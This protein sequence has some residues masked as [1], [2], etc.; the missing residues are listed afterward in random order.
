MSKPSVGPAHSAADASTH[1]AAHEPTIEPAIEATHRAADA[2]AD[3]AAVEPT[4]EAAHVAPLRT[5]RATHAPTLAPTHTPAHLAADSPLR[6]THRTAH[7][8]PHLRTRPHTQNGRAAAV[9][10]RGQ[11]GGVHRFRLDVGRV[12]CVLGRRC[13]RVPPR[14]HAR[15]PRVCG[16]AA[17]RR[18]RGRVRGAVR[19]AARVHGHRAVCPADPGRHPRLL[20]SR[21]AGACSS[22]CRIHRRWHGRW[23][24]AAFRRFRGVRVCRHDLRPSGERPGVTVP[25]CAYCPAWMWLPSLPSRHPNP[26][27]PTPSP[28]APIGLPEVANDR[29]ISAPHT[30]TPS[31]R[32]PLRP[33]PYARPSPWPLTHY[34]RPSHRQRHHHRRAVGYAGVRPR[35]G[36]APLVPPHARGRPDDPRKHQ[37]AVGGGGARWGGGVRGGD[38]GDRHRLASGRPGAAAGKP[39]DPQ[40]TAPPGKALSPRHPGPP[41]APSPPPLR[42]GPHT[43]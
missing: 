24:G 27:P 20:P 36:P 39:N 32:H 17:R 42:T 2:A 3:A 22:F 15:L 38:G 26:F 8:S 7:Q 31:P 28:G 37:N 6:P 23:R 18:R 14:A 1:K 29:N 30:L 25:R 9:H 13:G 16:R 43:A 5:H 34:S 40:L 10:C 33:P 35:Q 4:V 11:P 19:A 41:T 12:S 21:G